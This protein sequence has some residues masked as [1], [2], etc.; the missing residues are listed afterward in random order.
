MPRRQ[1]TTASKR[2]GRLETAVSRTVL[3]KAIQTVEAG[4]PLSG[5]TALWEQTAKR[6]NET[7][8]SDNYPPIGANT[9]RSRAE[10][11]DI[12]FRTVV[13]KERGGG[14]GG[15]RAERLVAKERILCPIT[16]WDTQMIERGRRIGTESTSRFVV[17]CDKRNWVVAKQV[18]D[19]IVGQKFYPSFRL[20]IPGAVKEFDFDPVNLVQKI[21]HALATLSGKPVCQAEQTDDLLAVGKE[22]DTYY[23]TSH[24][25]HEDVLN[26][27]FRDD[28]GVEETIEEAI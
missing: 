17:S 5:L 15:S 25:L 28:P 11:W 8:F 26:R 12:P 6:Y 2:Q 1:R 3:E 7:V 19:N 22:I 13:S 16:G 20:L 4:G 9:A 10:R 14:G 21:V 23:K 27:L 24:H 18:G